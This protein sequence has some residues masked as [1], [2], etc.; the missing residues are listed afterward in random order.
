VSRGSALAAA[1]AA[2]ACAFAGLAGLVAAGSLNGLDQ[3]AIDHLMP[4]GVES[5]SGPSLAEALVPL[6]H[7]HWD[8]A[9]RAAANVVTLPAQAFVSFALVGACCVLL[10]RRGRR[11]DAVTWAAAWVGANV[12]EVAGKAAIGRPPLYRNGLH[13]AAFD[14]SFP[15][16]HTVRAL[17]V[18]AVAASVWPRARAALA[19][20]AAATVVLLVVAGDHVPSDV[21]G[22]VA[23]AVLALALT[24]LPSSRPSSSCSSSSSS[25]S[26]VAAT[27][28]PT[29]PSRA[30]RPSAREP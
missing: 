8:Q 17:L 26:R 14:S 9:L 23:L 25:S 3:W 29:R 5:R 10:A 20:W 12:A 19:A 13:V 30:C 15:S 16:G 27:L 28:Q 1:A 21:A 6:L 2:A 7:A 18:A 11:R 22:G 4:G 24:G